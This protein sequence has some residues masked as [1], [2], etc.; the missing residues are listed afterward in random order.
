MRPALPGPRIPWDD[1]QFFVAVA[2]QGAVAKAATHLGVNH[3]TV[4]RRLSALEH[5]LGTRLFER[6]RDGYALTAAGNELSQRLRSLPDLVEG[7]HR[8][9]L[10]VAE[11]I[12]G[13][14]HLTSSDVVIESVLMPALATFRRRHPGVYVELFSNYRHAT[15]A[16]HEAEI[17]VRG[18]DEAPVGLVSRLVG[19]IETV[20]CASPTYLSV[21]VPR[22]WPEHRW[23]ALDAA[24]SFA[25]LQRWM[26]T[27]VPADRIVARID[28]I[29]GLADAVATGL[30]IG[31]IPR[32]L[33][34][35]RSLVELAPPLDEFRNPIW[36][37]MHPD[38]RHIPRM[39]ALFKHLV[40]ALLRSPAMDHRSAG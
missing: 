38:V 16:P 26:E 18:A 8:H 29:V 20:L 4:L 25:H 17:A 1:V 3:S 13:P 19:D 15:L 5:R 21:A 24:L 37:L 35:A 7:A 28:S 34:Q 27:H 9:A 40:E 11:E 6:L 14:I 32:P 23:L 12:R 33:A 31:W 39:Q 10:G 2:Q 22:P 30:G 36:V